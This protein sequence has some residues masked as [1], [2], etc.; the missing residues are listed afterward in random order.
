[1]RVRRFWNIELPEG[2]DL[3]TMASSPVAA[4]FDTGRNEQLWVRPGSVATPVRAPQPILALDLATLPDV[5]DLP[6]AHLIE[7]TAAADAVVDG[8]RPRLD[9]V[10]AP[11][12]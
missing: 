2:I 3:S 1:M 10:F 8:A 7:R 11:H 9:A 6:V 5:P 12:P 4:R